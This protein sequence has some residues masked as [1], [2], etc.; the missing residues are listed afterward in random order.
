VE[1]G[2]AFKILTCKAT[3]KRPLNRGEDNITMDHKETGVS[4]RNR[5]D[6]V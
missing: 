3:E 2:N 1:G 6:S 4:T 5:V